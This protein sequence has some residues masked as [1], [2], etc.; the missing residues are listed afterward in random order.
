MVTSP[1][2]DISKLTKYENHDVIQMDYLF[3]AGI[4]GKNCRRTVGKGGGGG[5]TKQTPTP[6]LVGFSSLAAW[7]SERQ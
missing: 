2:L 6:N 1:L 4:E 3:I 5:R 7:F